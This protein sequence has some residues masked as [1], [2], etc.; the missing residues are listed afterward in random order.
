[1][2]CG[3]CLQRCFLV[4][5]SCNRF[6]T[7]VDFC[8]TLYYIFC[9]ILEVNFTFC[10]TSMQIKWKVSDHLYGVHSFIVSLDNLT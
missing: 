8:R 10:G 6:D 9:I 5:M 3:Q 1:M 2:Y 4:L 7:A